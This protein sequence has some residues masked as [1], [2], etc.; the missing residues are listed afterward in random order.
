MCGRAGKHRLCS[1]NP[2]KI[3]DEKKCP[4]KNEQLPRP[5]RE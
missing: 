2:N 5:V 4:Q 1:M 3:N